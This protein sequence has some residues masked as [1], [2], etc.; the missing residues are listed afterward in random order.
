MKHPEIFHKVRK[1]FKTL[2]EGFVRFQKKTY[3]KFFFGVRKVSKKKPYEKVF[4]EFVR[5]QK[6]NLREG[7]E[8]L[9]GR[10]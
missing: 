9:T 1:V 8:N 7:F 5:F 4:W 2:R 10:F 6:T 3:E